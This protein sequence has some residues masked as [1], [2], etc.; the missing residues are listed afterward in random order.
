MAF[1]LLLAV[2]ISSQ[3]G[4][5]QTARPAR[6]VARRGSKPKRK[7]KMKTTN[8]QPQTTPRP[9]RTLPP[10]LWG[11]AH[12]SLDVTPDGARLEFDCAH[13]TIS[14]PITLAADN[15]FAVSGVYVPERGG[16]VR[17][18]EAPVNRQA[19]Y[20]GRVEGETMTL[21]VTRT[22]QQQAVGTYTLGLGQ[23][24]KVFKCR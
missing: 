9:A 24:P 1:V 12:V 21:T 18:D 5:G 11:G 4:Y 7:R 8:T 19:R 20:T 6:A 17:V 22:D 10:G 15:T 3:D 13:G 23:S 14:E 2:A 16:P